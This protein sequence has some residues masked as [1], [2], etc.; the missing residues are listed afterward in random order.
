MC[1]LLDLCE[2][3]IW[4]AISETGNSN[5]RVLCSRG[6]VE[7]GSLHTLRLESLKLVL[8]QPPQISCKQITV[9]ARR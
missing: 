5:E 2:T 3:F 9:L 6:T 1:F 8:Q 7:V 4:A